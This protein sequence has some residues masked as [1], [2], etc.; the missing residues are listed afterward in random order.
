M[1]KI[2]KI[3]REIKNANNA[4][5]LVPYSSDSDHDYY[6]FLK[7]K[8]SEG[9][10][11][12][13]ISSEIMKEII[14]HFYFNMNLSISSIELMEDDNEIQIEIKRLLDLMEKDRAY[15]SKL[16]DCLDFLQEKSSIDIKRVTFRNKFEHYQ[17]FIQVNGILG[18]DEGAYSQ[19]NKEIC[20][21][22]ERS[23]EL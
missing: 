16:S 20:H 10:N 21:L 12:V 5:T 15:Y 6:E 14:E 19:V 23:I 18:I 1:K 8:R 9:F 4:F 17:F 2:S 3:F 11:Q 22:L 13:I 7:R